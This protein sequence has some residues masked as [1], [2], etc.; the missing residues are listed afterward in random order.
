[1]NYLDMLHDLFGHYHAFWTAPNRVNDM[2]YESFDDY[3]LWFFLDRSELWAVFKD[4]KLVARSAL[5]T[6]V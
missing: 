1:M 5:Y 4:S 3:S 6:G 2:F